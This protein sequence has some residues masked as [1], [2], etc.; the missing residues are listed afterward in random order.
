M[1]ALPRPG[2]GHGD[3]LKAGQSGQCLLAQRHCG[4]LLLGTTSMSWPLLAR[5]QQGRSNVPI[6][7]QPRQHYTGPATGPCISGT[8]EWVA[9]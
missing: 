6:P 1:A 3:G 2:I 5:S 7:L 4:G 8:S 9:L